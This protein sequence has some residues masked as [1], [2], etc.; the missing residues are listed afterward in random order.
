M[1]FLFNHIR[2]ACTESTQTQTTT[3]GQNQ[4]YFVSS[5]DASEEDNETSGSL[6]HHNPLPG[7]DKCCSTKEM[8]VLVTAAPNHD[9]P[10]KSLGN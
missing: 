4:S 10:T 6:G 7:V 8:F 1:W 5:E 2:R 3:C 9:A